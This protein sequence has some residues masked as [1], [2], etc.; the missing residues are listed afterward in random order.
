MS[1]ADVTGRALE[2]VWYLEDEEPAAPAEYAFALN[3][4]AKD[5]EDDGRKDNAVHDE[6]QRAED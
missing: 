6:H 4:S 1:T 5:D 2:P 3:V